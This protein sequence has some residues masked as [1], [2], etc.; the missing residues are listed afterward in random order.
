MNTK[1]L[2]IIILVIGVLMMM[3]TGFTYFTTE[4]VVN[5]GSLHINK[6]KSHFISWP[7]IVGL[8][9]FLCG[10]LMFVNRKKV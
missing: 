5:I 9:L 8:L 3:Y 2:S 10:I 6:Q 1:I 4:N 7:P